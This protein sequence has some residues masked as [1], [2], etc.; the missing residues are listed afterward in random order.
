MAYIITRSHNGPFHAH[1][2]KPI[3]K[4][5]L[6]VAACQKSSNANVYAKNCLR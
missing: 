6:N 1:K 5:I 3:K 2:S 4:T